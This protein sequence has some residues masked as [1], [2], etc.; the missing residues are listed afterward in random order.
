MMVSMLDRGGKTTSIGIVP[1]S[2][3]KWAAGCA[4]K[5]PGSRYR[6]GRSPDWLKFKN[7]EAAA[8]KR[9]AEADWGR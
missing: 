5:R 9:Q 3:K 4:L 1:V 6:S 7:P 2:V 8:V